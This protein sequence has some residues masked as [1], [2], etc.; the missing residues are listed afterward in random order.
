MKEGKS[1]K[2]KRNEK[3]ISLY[4]KKNTTDESNNICNINN[5]NNNNKNYVLLKI[6][7]ITLKCVRY[8]TK[9]NSMCK[10]Y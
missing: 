10:M 5:Y 6:I 1:M 7:M 4:F 9:T 2:L 3:Q 8:T